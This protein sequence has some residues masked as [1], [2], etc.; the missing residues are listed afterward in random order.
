MPTIEVLGFEVAAGIL[1]SAH[2]RDPFDERFRLGRLGRTALPGRLGGL[3]DDVGLAIDLG[4]D[5]LGFLRGSA[6][7]DDAIGAVDLDDGRALELGA[8]ALPGTLQDVLLLP[9]AA[10]PNDD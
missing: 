3:Q 5:L 9:A 2:A 7:H 10:I 1:D 6:L 8:K 4:L